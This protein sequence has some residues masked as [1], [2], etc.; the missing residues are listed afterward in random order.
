MIDYA[1]LLGAM[2]DARPE[3]RHTI[4]LD[5]R[6]N[7]PVIAAQQ[8]LRRAQAGATA[9]TT[10]GGQRRMNQPSPVET[11]EV[12]LAAALAAARAASVVFITT[13][14]FPGELKAAY[15][16]A[17]ITGD[18]RT[19][20]IAAAQLTAAYRRAETPDGETIPVLDRAAYQQALACLPPDQLVQEAD[21]L[22]VLSE[23]P[24]FG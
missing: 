6:L 20:E 10:G 19:Y 1:T 23:I 15:E 14:A 3:H 22:R 4:V 16:E 5:P 12:A 11:A 13:P 8:A 9:T 7:P 24:D 18:S 2:H 21:R 17:G